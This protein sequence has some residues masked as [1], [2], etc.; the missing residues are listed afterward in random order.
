MNVNGKPC[1]S[2]WRSEDGNS[3]DIIDQ[4]RLPHEFVTARLVTV[5]N[6][7]RAIREM[8]VRGA[9]LIGVTAAYG[10]ALAMHADPSD[11]SLD[12]AARALLASRPTA[13]NL[14]WGVERLRTLLVPLSKVSRSAAAWE[15]AGRIAEE[16]VAI[17]AGIG[18]RGREL[19]EAIY[20]R[21]KRSVNVLT[22][23]N[24][25]WLATVDWGTAL[26][27][28]YAAF[29]A[30]IPLHVWVDETRPRNQGAGLTAWELG[31]H[32]VPYSLIVDNAGGHLMQHGMVDLLLVGCDRVTA[33]GDVCNKIGTYLKALAAH[34]NGVPF[35][36]AL[37]S[38]T[39]DWTLDDGVKEIP[40]EE[41]SAH[42]VT[43]LSGR[44][45]DGHIELVSLAP[46]GARAANY[47]F[48]VTPARL[49]TAFVTER[50]VLPADRE[51]L[52]ALHS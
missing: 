31:Q 2:I 14:R 44:T 27:P 6:V 21:E 4:T 38:P 3:V 45:K 33:R 28:V 36:V 10:M 13:V 5:D 15:E 34:D 23:C 52:R 12:K 20:R 48:D 19:I 26:A 41:R 1:R 42:E 35:Y 8:W 32:G 29:D 18:C 49:V 47:G 16:D 43:H 22:H 51:S 9:P 24:A 46:E 40:I 11:A 39:V 7:E 30:G 37:P 50:G 17:N 25:G